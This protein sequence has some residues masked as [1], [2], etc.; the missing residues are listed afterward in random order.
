MG[1]KRAGW[2]SGAGLLVL[3]LCVAAAL[4]AI[5]ND[6]EVEEAVSP[7]QDARTDLP[8]S[9]GI[10]EAIPAWVQ[11]L[12]SPS[13]RDLKW[14]R[15]QQLPISGMRVWAVPG[16]TRVCLIS[17]QA[18]KTLGVACAL[19]G[20]IEDHG[21]AITL[22]SDAHP[23]VRNR[24]TIVGIAPLGTATVLAQSDDGATPIKVVNGV[25][26]RRDRRADPPSR[27]TLLH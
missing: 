8:I 18:V 2:H 13:N 12:L 23:G 10:P 17:Q 25:F 19:R 6:H 11:R 15:A 20:Q 5:G 22:L 24:R 4:S 27:Y 21:L 1:R 14:N 26:I 9:E 16:S 7:A 3:V